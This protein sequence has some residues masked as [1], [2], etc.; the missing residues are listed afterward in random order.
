MDSTP[1]TDVP[2]KLA[3]HT[4]LVYGLGD[5]TVNLALTS[6]QFFFG[7][8][9]TEVAGL[10]PALAGLVPLVGRA[11]DAFTDPTMGRLS[12]MTRW[13]AGRR[14]PWLLIGMVPFGVMFTL[15][16]SDP[17]AETSQGVKFAWFAMAYVLFSLSST[18]IAVPYL[19]LTPEMTSSYDER[20][21]MNAF[22]AALAITGTLV[23]VT[24]MRPLA[25]AFGGGPEGWAWAGRTYG[26]WLVIPW[27]AVWAVTFERRSEPPRGESFFAGVRSLFRHPSYQWLTALYIL[28]RVALD[29][30][31]AMFIYYFTFWLNRSA[32]FELTMGLF[33]VTV[34]VVLPFWLSVARRFDKRVIFIAGALSWVVSCM[35]IFAGQP[36]WPRW[37][38]FVL[39]VA[40]GAG[41]AASDLMPWSMLGEVVDEDELRG[42]HRREG[43]YYGFF[44]F[45]RK[46]G[47]ALGVAIA[48]LVLDLVGF[49]SGSEEPQ[50][51]R[52]LFTIR[53]LTAVVPAT[54]VLLAAFVALRYPLSRARHEEILVEL[55]QR[56]E[57]EAGRE[58]V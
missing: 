32:D 21:S 15:L 6:L 10:R 44:T 40:A 43:I 48:F 16:W 37:A 11:V 42:G 27:L 57:R 29:L 49:Q 58:D 54:L 5:H 30:T 51:D 3:W 38:M 23:A 7:F 46:L 35:I 19:A 47:G 14:R 17:G 41:Y 34:I 13:K 12:D 1:P 20:T 24:T 39:A 45:L 36:E 18:V 26:V 22:R 9:L 53:V 2:Q 31:V 55:E 25:E 28:S 52:A 56:R 4:K 8:F 50:S 33:L